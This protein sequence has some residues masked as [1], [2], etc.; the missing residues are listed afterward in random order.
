[1]GHDSV[2]AEHIVLG[3]LHDGGPAVALFA[4]L[5]LNVPSVQKKLEASGRRA[6]QSRRGDEL[7]YTSH[8]K[9]LIEAA[10]KEARES[11]TALSAEHLLLAALQEPRGTVAKILSEADVSSGRARDALYHS[12]EGKAPVMALGLATIV[13]AIITLDGESHWFEGVQLLAVYGMMAV[14]AY[15]LV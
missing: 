10:S 1:L 12:P 7:A 8:A 2:G 4:A 13:T 5:G 3:L 14:R 6:K 9:R 15:F 11:G